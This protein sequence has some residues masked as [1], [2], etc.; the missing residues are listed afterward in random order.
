MRQAK[1]MA[2]RYRITGVPAVI[3]NGKY[4]TSGPLAKSNENIVKVIE[5]LIQQESLA[6]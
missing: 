4:K 1:A 5:Q 2:P 6:K 3:I